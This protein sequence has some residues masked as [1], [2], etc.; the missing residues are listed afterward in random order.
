MPDCRSRPCAGF[1]VFCQPGFGSAC[2]ACA[3]Q[4]RRPSV[5]SMAGNNAAMARAA[6]TA[7]SATRCPG[8]LPFSVAHGC[9][10]EQRQCAHGL[11]SQAQ[12]CAGQHRGQG[13]HTPELADA[14]DGHPAVGMGWGQ[15]QRHRHGGRFLRAD[16]A[17]EVQVA[18]LC[19]TVDK[20]LLAVVG[21]VDV[22]RHAADQPGLGIESLDREIA[23]HRQPD[24]ADPERGQAGA[25]H[26]HHRRHCGV[27]GRADGHAALGAGRQRVLSDQR[28]QGAR[29]A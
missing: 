13:G 6:A 8:A 25:R 27:E 14:A 16:H 24:A 19:R 5:F 3:Q 4:A 21:G 2:M 18:A 17:V 9:D 10:R 11:V 28:G 22:V 12:Q 15:Q 7:A 20:G 23:V 26:F 1:V 29:P